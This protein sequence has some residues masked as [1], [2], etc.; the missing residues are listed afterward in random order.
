[1][2][3]YKINIEYEFQN[4]LNEDIYLLIPLTKTMIKQPS[5][6]KY[7]TSELSQDAAIMWLLEWANP[8]HQD[9]CPKLHQIGMSLLTSFYNISNN[10]LED[11][12]SLTIFSQ[13]RKID[14]LV[15]VVTG[16]K[17]TAILIEDKIKSSYHSDQ[18]KRYLDDLN[19]TNEYDLVIPIYFKTGFQAKL[20]VVKETGYYHFNVEHFYTI[21]KQGYELGID[22]DI[23]QDLHNHIKELHQN[24]LNSRDSFENY[25]KKNVEDWSWWSWNGFFNKY[26]TTFSK[27]EEGWGVV[28]S[29]R[30]SLLASWFGHEEFV[31]EHEG[32]KILFKP[33]IDVRYEGYSNNYILSYRLHLNKNEK[34]HKEVRDRIKKELIPRLKEFELDVKESKFRK[35]KKTIE[36]LKVHSGPLDHESELLKTLETLKKI[37][38]DS[39]IAAKSE[40]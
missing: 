25:A 29:R 30:G 17:K 15:E 1:V 34:H 38:T 8:Y 3:P 5:I 35:A 32:K 28:P 11:F 7:A 40:A 27:N 16:D 37:L 39:V 24:Y 26:E 12:D 18:L 6:F 9:N 2:S 31:H 4:I 14:I 22:N 20:Q 23:F 33:F 36:I 10:T 21:L 19:S 13:V